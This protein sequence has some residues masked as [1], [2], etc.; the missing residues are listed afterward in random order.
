[1]EGSA[2]A[3]LARMIGYPEEVSPDATS[4]SFAVDDGR[5]EA[6]EEGGRLVLTREVAPAG[7]VDLAQ[8]AEYAA[9]RCLREDA[10][11]AYDQVGDRLVLWQ[12]LPSSVEPPLLRR[13]F[14]VF[15]S[16]CDWWLARVSGS[17]GSAS[18]PDMMIRP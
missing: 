11:L 5:I 6:V 14:E 18:I 3:S 1:M 4:F 9:G 13:F 15:A 8:F 2:I 17:A 16:S 12:D 7:D 10:T